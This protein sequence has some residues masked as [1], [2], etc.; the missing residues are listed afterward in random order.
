MRVFTVRVQTA[1]SQ[2]LVQ[3]TCMLSF[4]L[5]KIAKCRLNLAQAFS[6]RC[7]FLA[8]FSECL[9]V[10]FSDRVYAALLH[11]SRSSVSLPVKHRTRL[12]TIPIG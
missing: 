1:V 2:C 6:Q 12:N 5:R 3:Q 8:V 7:N 4:S 11:K 10:T 9:S